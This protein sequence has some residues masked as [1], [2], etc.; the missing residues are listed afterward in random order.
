MMLSFRV[1]PTSISGLETPDRLD[2]IS[3]LLIGHFGINGQRERFARGAL[4]LR[5]ITFA[6][7]QIR[8]ALLTVKWNRVIH[9]SADAARLQMF[10]ER[11]A[12]SG[13][14][15]HVLMKYV[16]SIRTNLRRD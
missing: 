12:V 9:F 5:K 15:N 6:V 13:N 2:Y 7:T 1:I 14:P 10:H 16:T 11:I 4:R 8:E 3:L